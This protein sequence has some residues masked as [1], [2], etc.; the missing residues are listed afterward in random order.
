MSLID[1]LRWR[2]NRWRDP[3]TIKAFHKLAYRQRIYNSTTW[4]GHQVMQ[5]PSDLLV[6]QEI[7]HAVKPDVIV[8]CG[9]YRGGSALFYAH[10]LDLIGK[11]RVVSIDLTPQPNLPLHPRIEY[12]TGSTIDPAVVASVKA[13]AQGVVMVCL[14]SLH[15][16]DHVYAELLAYHSLVTSGSYLIVED[17]EMNGHPVYTDFAP[18]IGPGPWEAIHDFLPD[19]PEFTIDRN[20]E[21]YLVTGHADGWLK[22]A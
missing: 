18:E 11:G 15:T 10:L 1:K 3:R 12:L 5:Y 20:C 22:R 21:R 19:H 14:D 16:R 2:F 13:K 17:G 9:T 8:E 4:M 6:K 7:I